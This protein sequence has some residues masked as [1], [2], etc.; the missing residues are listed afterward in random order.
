[1]T[2]S[3]RDPEYVVVPPSE[4][5]DRDDDGSDDSDAIDEATGNDTEDLDDYRDLDAPVWSGPE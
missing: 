1:M 2:D 4:R 3:A 5:L